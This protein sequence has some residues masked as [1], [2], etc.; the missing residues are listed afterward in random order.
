MKNIKRKEEGV[1][2]VIATILM[3]AITVVLAATLYMMLPSGGG[4]DSPV[5]GSM[6]YRSGSSNS[7]KAVF[8]LT[9]NT[10]S[11]ADYGDLKITLLGDDGDVNGT[12][13][14]LDSDEKDFNLED[15]VDD[16]GTVTLT[17]T[18][19][20][21]DAGEIAG[22]DR[23]TIESNDAYGGLSGHEIVISISGYSGSI[24]GNV[25]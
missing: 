11:S 8:G 21:S 19:I 15:D 24:N 6:T 22:G 4:G 14:N 5:A 18:K 23:I 17:V 12:I 7:T 1:S 3:V 20:S 13:S 16:D 10:P 2:P 9:M 25:P